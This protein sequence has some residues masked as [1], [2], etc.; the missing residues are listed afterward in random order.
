MRWLSTPEDAIGIVVLTADSKEIRF[1][2]H[3][4]E[5]HHVDQT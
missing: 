3:S 4:K 1:I 5:K 2:N